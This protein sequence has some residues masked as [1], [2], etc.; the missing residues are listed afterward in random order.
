MP[1]WLI[2]KLED[3]G[4]LNASAGGA[5]A[6]RKAHTVFCPSCHHPVMR[7]LLD[8][9]TPWL[10]DADPTPLSPLGEVSALLAGVVTYTLSWNGDRY[11]LDRRY[12]WQIRN[13]PAATLKGVDLLAEHR[14][15]QPAKWP[16]MPTQ[17]PAKPTISS[18][19]ELPQEAPF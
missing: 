10:V 14:C 8:N 17:L 12:Q 15:R 9:P 1:S 3:D 6:T 2:R 18:D 11:E 5:W 19:S 4:V 7:G 13:H 16:T